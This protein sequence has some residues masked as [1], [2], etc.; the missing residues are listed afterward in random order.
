MQDPKAPAPL[1]SP[2]PVRLVCPR[3]L[4]ESLWGWGSPASR[5]CHTAHVP[6]DV[7]ILAG[8]G[9]QASCMGYVGAPNQAF[10]WEKPCVLWVTPAG[11][12]RTPSMGTEG[13]LGIR[14][15]WGL[16]GHVAARGCP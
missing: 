8:W 11:D 14:N 1:L 10:L 2:R 3:G 13:W 15:F 4:K 9:C 16:K 6:R 12:M 5:D 7:T